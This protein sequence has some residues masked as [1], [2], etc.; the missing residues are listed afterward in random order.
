[1]AGN[2]GAGFAARSIS[3]CERGNDVPG[4]MWA[5]TSEGVSQWRPCGMLA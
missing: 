3:V 2:E 5:I 1:M 4:G